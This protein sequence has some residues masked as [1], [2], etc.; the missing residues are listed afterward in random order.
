MNTTISFLRSILKVRSCG[1][2]GREAGGGASAA[3]E[4]K[5]I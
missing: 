3:I 1:E 2:G 4:S 5:A